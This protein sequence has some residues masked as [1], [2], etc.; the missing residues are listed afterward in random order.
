MSAQSLHPGLRAYDDNPI[1]ISGFNS[2]SFPDQKKKKSIPAFPK[3]SLL[4]FL[5]KLTTLS[6][7]LT[8]AI[9]NQTMLASSKTL[10]K[11]S[12]H[13]QFIYHAISSLKREQKHQIPWNDIWTSIQG[14]R[15]SNVTV[16]AILI[17]TQIK[18]TTGSNLNIQAE[19]SRPSRELCPQCVKPCQ[20]C[21]FR[22]MDGWIDRKINRFLLLM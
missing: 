15:P 10:E 9:S 18:G 17:S 2:N 11:A 12:K 14:P 6:L 20:Q 8:S 3:P 13:H 4:I 21:I 22:W 19:A 16:K 1:K 7:Y 5:C